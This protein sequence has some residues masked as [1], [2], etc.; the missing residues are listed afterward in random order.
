[1]KHGYDYGL[2]T[3]EVLLSGSVG[4]AK[5]ILAAHKGVEHVTEFGGAR[6]ILGR[7]ALPDLKATIFQK[8]LEHLDGTFERGHEY[9]VRENIGHIKFWN[10]SEIVS[11]SWADKRYKKFRSLECSAAIVEELTENNQDDKS[12][13]EELKMRLGRL[14]HVPENWLIAPTNPDSPKHWAYSRFMLSKLPTR[15]VYYSNTF[16]N[17]FLDASYIDG[18]LADLD[19]KMARRMVYGEWI[20]IASENVYYAYDRERN[21]VDADYA[22]DP[23]LPIH[24][25]FDF[26]IGVGKPM[27][28]TLYQIDYS[29]V[30]HF[31]D[32]S[33]I[34]GARTL[35]IMEE[36]ANRGYFELPNRWLIHGDASG[37]HKDT[38][39]PHSDY[40]IISKFFLDYRRKD[41]STLMSRLEVPAANPSLRL[42]HNTVNGYLLN[43]TG[44]VRIKVYRKAKVLDE[45]FRLV[46]LRKLA[47]Y[48]EDDSKYYQHVTTAAGYGIVWDHLTKASK[49]QGSERR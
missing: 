38:R 32:E 44:A 16:D 8:I 29:G 6:L 17:P 37:K 21:W 23:L 47:E 35:N 31:F 42:R 14:P 11:R 24:L 45:G 28:A 39:S 4:S 49:P 27:S 41:G 46:E 22:I 10:G 2:G 13:Y 7:K 43:S 1:M 20:E 40:D 18:V 48:A 19:P 15:H 5:S 26:N 36:L 30:F 12:A 3:H 34:E 25:T 33:V 9:W